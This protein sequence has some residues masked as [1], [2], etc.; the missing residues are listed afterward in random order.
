MFFYRERVN[1]DVSI[2]WVGFFSGNLCSL[3]ETGLG[4][5]VGSIDIIIVFVNLN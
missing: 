2:F 3:F 5:R 1:I 4:F